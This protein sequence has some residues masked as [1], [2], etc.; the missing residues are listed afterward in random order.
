MWSE[1]HYT[2]ATYRLIAYSE[3][4]TPSTSP[5]VH[6]CTCTYI[7]TAWGTPVLRLYNGSLLIRTLW[8]TNL[9]SNAVCVI[10]DDSNQ[11]ASLIRT[12]CDPTYGV[13]ISY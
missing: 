9:L 8:I 1:S 13:H 3:Y 2:C 12:L 11:D 10:S 6:T 5:L 4:P 7:V